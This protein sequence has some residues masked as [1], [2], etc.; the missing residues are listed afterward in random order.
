MGG[1]WTRGEW[2]AVS[3]RLANPTKSPRLRTLWNEVESARHTWLTPS[4]LAEALPKPDKHLSAHPAIPRL[5]SP[6][7]RLGHLS[8][9]VVHGSPRD[10]AY[11]QPRLPVVNLESAEALRPAAALP[12]AP[13][14]RDPHGY[15]GL[16][17]PLLVLAISQPTP[18]GT[19]QRFRRC[20]RRKCCAAVGAL[21]TPSRGVP[22]LG[23][24][25]GDIRP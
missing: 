2:P 11:C 10:P 15:Y 17:A 22:R 25:F 13:V 9:N 18:T 12:A 19:S 5:L 24:A 14:G 7:G 4:G 20:S 23:L 21:W 16:S 6:E 1:Y 8:R 3:S